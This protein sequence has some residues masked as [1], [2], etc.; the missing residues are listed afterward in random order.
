MR[1]LLEDH[2]GV[3]IVGRISMAFSAGGTRRAQSV[4]DIMRIVLLAIWSRS[5]SSV[6]NPSDRQLQSCVKRWKRLRADRC[7]FVQSGAGFLEVFRYLNLA[8]ESGRVSTAP[9]PRLTCFWLRPKY[10]SVKGLVSGIPQKGTSIEIGIS[11]IL[12]IGGIEQLAS[13]IC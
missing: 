3:R 4:E 1:L 12:K 10:K 13:C 9:T 6:G 2:R 8:P 7:C 11:P 5:R